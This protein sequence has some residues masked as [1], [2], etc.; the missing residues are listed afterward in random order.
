MKIL[1]IIEMTVV[2][3]HA[4]ELTKVVFCK[5]L[6]KIVVIHYLGHVVYFLLMKY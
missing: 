3:L 6:V 5:G 2:I 1:D 4:F